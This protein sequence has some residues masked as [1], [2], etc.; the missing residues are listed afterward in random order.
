MCVPV[1]SARWPLAPRPITPHGL[2]A[3][4]PAHNASCAGGSQA[5][6]VCAVPAACWPA[7]DHALRPAPRSRGSP[8]RGCALLFGRAQTYV[9][10]ILCAINPFKKIPGIYEQDKSVLYTDVS[11]QSS[12][13]PHL[14]AT[15]DQAFSSM[16]E[17]QGRA[18][19]QVCVI[20]GESG[21]GKTESAK[22]FVKHV[23]Y[24]STL[25]NPKEGEK[26]GAGL[27][28][29]IVQLN[30]LLES[31]GNAQTLMNDNSSR[32]GKFTELRFNATLGITVRPPPAPQCRLLAA[33]RPCPCHI[34][35]PLPAC[36]RPA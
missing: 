21:A 17:N 5:A 10:D 24:L 34:C 1:T 31:L 33:P 16:A 4:A 11:D 29:K 20:S 19:N 23:I 14:F 8:R 18:A 7:P 3:P 9:G 2:A 22:L 35:V 32:F 27:E 15:A 25:K 13:P 26:D 30:P 28:E 6:S 12:L 36:L